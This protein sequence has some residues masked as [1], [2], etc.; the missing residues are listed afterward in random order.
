VYFWVQEHTV[1]EEWEQVEAEIF[2]PLVL[3]RRDPDNVSQ[4]VV[5]QEM[6]M[7][8]NFTRQNDAIARGL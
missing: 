4:S 3:G 5:E 7:F 6:T 8:A 2:E 1:P